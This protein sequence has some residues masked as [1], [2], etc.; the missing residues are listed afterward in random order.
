[1]ANSWTT[2]ERNLFDYLLTVFT[3]DIE[4]TTAFIGEY[5]PAFND[6]DIDYLWFVSIDGGGT[7]DDVGAGVAYCGMNAAARFEG[8]F[9]SR[10]TAQE[11][12]I[13][14]KN[15]LP[16]ASGTVVNVFDL[17]LESEPS[18]ERAVV[19]RD[20]DQANAGEIRVWRLMVPL[21]C[22]VSGS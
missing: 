5:P 16:L 9:E 8:I 11:Y 14:V 10:E 3:A 18:I 4:D 2:A 7:P 19:R 21:S 20:P 12:G 17:R 15:L 22:V 13:A 1:M 6:E